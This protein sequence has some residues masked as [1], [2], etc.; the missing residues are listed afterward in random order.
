MIEELKKWIIDVAKSSC[1]ATVQGAGEVCDETLKQNRE[2][3]NAAIPT[4]KSANNK[5]YKEF[6]KKFVNLL[7]KRIR[8]K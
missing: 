6:Q 7:S 8:K 2:F 3:I 5:I 1:D 4:E